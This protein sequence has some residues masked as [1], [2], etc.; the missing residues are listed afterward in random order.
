MN[1]RLLGRTGMY[2][3][4]ICLGT[5][6]YGG[7]GFWTAIGQ[8]PQDAV[9]KHV[10]M[11]WDA[12]V[13]F[14]DTANIYSFGESEELFGQ[15]IKD[16]GI[17]RHEMVIAT[18]VRGRMADGP[19]NVGLSRKHILHQLDE[20]LKRLG[21]DYIDLYQIH[22]VDPITPLDETLSALNDAVR[23]GKVRYIGVSNHTAWQMMKA[24]ASS[25]KHS[26]ARFESIQAYYSIAG[27]DL[28]REVIPFAQDQNLGIMVWSPMAGGFLSGKFRRDGSAPED[29]RRSTFD[30]PPINKELAYDLIEK[31]EH[32]IK[33]LGGSILRNWAATAMAL[34]YL[35]GIDERWISIINKAGYLIPELN[36]ISGLQITALENGTNSYKMEFDELIDATA[37]SEYLYKHNILWGPR[38]RDA[39]HYYFVVNESLLLKN[40]NE[41]IKAWDNGIRH[42][43]K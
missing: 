25:E 40:S 22:G 1:Y 9:N 24:Q 36:R 14:F 29:A 12:G 42:S 5:M 30:F 8:M 34:H 13:N 37:L 27:R 11:A 2:V 26:W 15:A 39:Q 20:S 32:Q 31:M 33:I 43:R 16:T 4:E 19:N 38:V 28:E 35:D 21:T 7:K 23:S 18:K 41:L 3:S 6:T 17:S 10:K